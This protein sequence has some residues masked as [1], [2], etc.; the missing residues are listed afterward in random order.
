MQRY[1]S[2]AIRSDLNI[3]PAHQTPATNVDVYVRH[4]DNSLATIYSVNDN[5]SIPI[6]QPLVTGSS[7]NFF[8]YAEN[9]RYKLD[10]STGDTRPDVILFDPESGSSITSVRY[11]IVDNPRLHILKKNKI[12]SVVSGA[13]TVSRST[14]GNY[15]DIYRVVKTAAA[16]ILRQESDGW[17]IENASTNLILR[18]DEFNDA[19][20]SVQDVTI[21]AN[22][23][24]SP[25]GTVTADRVYPTSTGT[26]RLVFQSA[27]SSVSAHTVSI[28]IK[29]VGFNW[30]KLLNAEGTSGV[31]FDVSNGAIGTQ[32][33]GSVGSIQKLA[34]GWFRCSVTG[35]GAASSFVQLALADSDGSS[36]ATALG[37]NGVF[38]WGAQLEDSSVITS[39]IQTLGSQVSRDVDS[40]TVQS[41]Y[42]FPDLSSSW[43][44]FAMIKAPIPIAGDC[45]IFSIGADTVRVRILSDS[46]IVYQDSGGEL[47]LGNHAINNDLYSFCITYDCTNMDL[48]INGDLKSSN[49]M[50]TT[51]FN[52]SDVINIFKNS[53]S[54]ALNGVGF[55][56]KV[57]DFDLSLGENK[58]LAGV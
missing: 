54:S 23:T 4:L 12:E 14:N 16:D 44:V 15:T 58:Y 50:T 57:Y 32:E 29:S 3:D 51:T 41:N 33:A 1:D 6:T 11:S 8:F 47:S 40:M 10:F 17:L 34:N 37:N 45:H 27:P 25:D 31:W 5:M 22:D 48:Y 55:D 19:A 26:N 43:S 38:V 35:N 13:T 18:S 2:D 36:V 20:W 52:T 42:N 24:A 30:V 7:G 39:Y 28:Y 49:A 46:D 56:F 53:T 9:G 21:S